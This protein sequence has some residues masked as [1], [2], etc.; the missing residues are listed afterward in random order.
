MSVQKHQLLFGWYPRGLKHRQQ[1]SRGLIHRQQRS[2]G[3]IHRQ[4][5]YQ[6]CYLSMWDVSLLYIMHIAEFATAVSCHIFNRCPVLTILTPGFTLSCMVGSGDHYIVA[7]RYWWR[8]P[9][10]STDL[11]QVT[12]T[13]YHLMLYRVHLDMSGNRTHTD[14]IGSWKSN[15]HTIM[16]MMAPFARS[17]LL[18]FISV[19]C[20]IGFVLVF[21]CLACPMLPVSRGCSFVIAPISFLCCLGFFLVFICLACQMLPVSRGCPFVIAPIS[22]L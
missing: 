5:R 16:P 9:E 7:V 18:I 22:F 2:R 4:Q 17:V 19:Q 13:L 6:I 20:C 15:Y 14:W 1:R 12:D 21:I 8:K 10:K 11:P 3:L